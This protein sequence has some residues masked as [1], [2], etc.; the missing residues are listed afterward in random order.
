MT[1]PTLAL[2]FQWFN[3]GDFQQALR[4]AESALARQPQDCGWLALQGLSLSAL[5]QPEQAARIYQQLCALEPDVPE[6]WMN[7]GNAQL[8]LGVAQAAW[9]SLQKARAMGAKDANLDFALARAS[10]E[11]DEPHTARAHVLAALQGGLG[12]DLEVAVLY[13]KCLIALDETELAQDNA[14]RLLAAPM[15]PD[16]ACEFAFLVLQLSDFGGVQTVAE[17][18]PESAPEFVHA[19][20][21]LG[22]SYERANQLEKMHAVRARISALRP[23]WSAEA[24]LAQPGRATAGTGAA[25]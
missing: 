24:P 11:L 19:L 9:K 22:L 13:L 21:G 4:A 17:K 2:V 25:L 3:Q 23:G 12:Q 20:I 1:T 14:K 8:E 15:P 16:L 18:I 5:K 7:L 6:H 10:L